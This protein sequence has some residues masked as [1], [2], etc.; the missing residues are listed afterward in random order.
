MHTLAEH[1]GDAGGAAA[2][3]VV[4]RVLMLLQATS[5]LLSAGRLGYTLQ[6]W[7]DMSRVQ[8]MYHAM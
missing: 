4:L 7:C 1:M 5:L 2:A 6:V 3:A 8:D